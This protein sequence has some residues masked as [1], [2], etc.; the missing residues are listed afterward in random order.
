MNVDNKRTEGPRW[1]FH[2]YKTEGPR[3]MF[4]RYKTEGPRWM[5]LVDII[6]L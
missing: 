2:R 3:W 1:M 5:L 6:T 4:H